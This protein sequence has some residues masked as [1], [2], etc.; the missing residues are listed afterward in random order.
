M[1]LM[2]S[3][4]STQL[5][6]VFR[7]IYSGML[8]L[9]K[10]KYFYIGA[11]TLFLGSQLNYVSQTYLHIYT[12]DGKNLPM[13]SDLILDN[14]PLWDISLIYDIFA[15][16]SAI[17]F[18]SFVV[19]KN[20]FNIVPYALLLTGIFQIVRAVFIILTPL[21]NPPDFVGSD[22]MFNGFAKYDLG[23]Y[24][25]GHIGT[26][27]LYFLLVNEKIYKSLLFL[28][29]IIITAALFLSRAH[30]SIDVLSGIFFAYAIKS[31]GDKY[32]T[33]FIINNDKSLPVETP[34]IP[35]SQIKM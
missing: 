21:G 31:F 12:K 15:I 22:E 26:A 35:S 28:C 4:K 11:T 19:H 33:R 18:F 9:L 27:F 13:L 14:I 2:I 16:V 17:V 5:T 34:F 1:T 30:Y 25:S 3:K 8:P 20:E 7:K 32:L 10:S 29:V 23:V 6:L 24:P